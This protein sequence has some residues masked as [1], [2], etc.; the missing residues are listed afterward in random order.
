MISEDGRME[1]GYVYLS[2][3]G[4]LLPLVL[5]MTRLVEVRNEESTSKDVVVCY[6]M[7]C[8]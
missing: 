3:G 1:V 5:K 2:D 8:E 6:R 7:C 4:N